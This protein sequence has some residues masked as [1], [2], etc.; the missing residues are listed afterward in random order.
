MNPDVAAW[1]EYWSAGGGRDAVSTGA[2][3]EALDGVWRDRLTALDLAP[4]RVAD[5]ACGIGAT[6]RLLRAVV[7]DGPLLVTCD[8]AETGARQAAA[9][10][11][12]APVAADGAAL[13][14]RDG[15]FDLVVSQF[16][17]EY[18][19][20]DAFAEAGRVLIGTGAGLAV[21]HLKDGAIE[22]ECADNLTVLDTF[23]TSGLLETARAAVGSGRSYDLYA[24]GCIHTVAGAANAR[25]GSAASQ[26]AAA[27]APDIAKL[28]ANPQAF[29]RGE[30]MAYMDAQIAA[31]SAYRARM[32]SMV[33]AALNEIGAGAA[34]QAFA[35]GR[36]ASC[37]RLEG[38]KGPYAWLLAVGAA[39]Q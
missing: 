14:F 22:R 34:L 20:P 15:A 18:A 26:F 10:S 23:F 4:E 6:S 21:V 12:G 8:V 1:R 31:I 17:L 5:L 3:G 25:P 27:T 28:A 38:P 32:A 30:A 24:D 9:N 39:V 37:S 19:G 11:N 2:A 16:G 29:E 13:A 7:G 35:A 33:Q 36:A